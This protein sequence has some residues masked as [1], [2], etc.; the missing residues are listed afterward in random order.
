M[1]KTGNEEQSEPLVVEE[2]LP[3][4]DTLA[5]RRRWPKVLGIVLGALAGI[6][7]VA[8]IG[9]NVFVR[10]AYAP[11]YQQ[12]EV[13]FPIPAV[14]NGFICQ[15]LDRLEHGDAWLFSGYAA[16]HGPSPVYRRSAD[17]SVQQLF[18]AFP[19][20]AVYDGH[21]SAIT[22]S[23][24]YVYVACE[25]GLLV[26]EE[27][28]FTEAAD[29]DIVRALGKIELDFTPA[30]ANVEGN[31][32]LAG[33]FYHPGSY[34][35]P[36]EHHVLTADGTENPAVIYAY[37][38]SD[39]AQWGLVDAPDA[40]LSIPE[41]I[42]GTCLTD[43]G[44][45]VLSQSYGLATSHL[46]AYDT[47]RLTQDGTFT[48]DGQEVPLYCLDSRS[49]VED[50]AAPP[51]TEGIESYEGRVYVSEESASNRYIFGKLYGAGVVYALDMNE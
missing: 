6:A 45:I 31:Y 43:D 44:R 8:L 26:F 13:A 12:A 40:V 2:G 18:L 16:D 17:G 25:G 42:Q 21:G 1:D 4:E 39:T 47:T 48:A 27:S 46:L 15:D 38:I 29:G 28:D 14:N 11:F 51:M 41:R 30:F 9:V 36:D 32:L 23:G 3:Q 22:S 19:D 50:V 34:E 5:K 37:P 7:L 24:R 33:N 49:L 20:G 10:V 35:T